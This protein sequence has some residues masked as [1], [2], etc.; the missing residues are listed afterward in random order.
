[1]TALV[2]KLRDRLGDSTLWLD[3]PAD[4]AAYARDWTGKHVG[5]TPLVLRPR[6]TEEVST[7]L[8]ACAALGVP[9][10]PQGG[11][12]GM[13]GGSVPRA[14]EVVLS[15]ERLDAIEDFDEG[16]ATVRV[17]AGVVLER[18]QG[19]LRE[20]GYDMPVDLGARGSCRIGGMIAT[21]AGGI[22]VLRY[23][24]MR[25][26]V[27]GLEV[28][29]ADGTVLDALN[30][31]KKN[32]TGLDLK[33]L[34]VGSEGI[35]GVVTRAVL[36]IQPAPE[37]FQ[38][39]LLAVPRRDLL[40]GLLADARARF[41][42]L[43]SLE[44]VDGATVDWLRSAD[45][46]FRSPLAWGHGSYVVIEEE[47]TAGPDAAAAFA[48]RLEGLFSDGLI[49]DAAVAN[50]GA[51]A[52]AIWRL[53]EAPTETVSRVG[54]THK[55]DVT[56]PPG[57]IPAFLDEMEAVASAEGGVRAI[58]FGHLGDGNVHVNMAQ[59]PGVP[60]DAFRAKEAVLAE[61]IY[62]AVRERRGSVSAEHGIG[63]MK[64]AYL[65]YS[66]TGGEIALMRTLKKT[67]D[68]KGILNP[69]VMLEP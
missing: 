56:V 15:T 37:A 33:Q 48:T 52:E 30:T 4:T 16:A 11:N 26:Q 59:E 10:V 54:L 53:R 69:G 5:E 66:R 60:D 51:Q 28:V 7:V 44:F 64:R 57:T 40:P 29:L 21:N 43:S 45:S 22:K 61:R 58:L 27:R 62:G 41:R 50:S 31:L 14:G 6:S 24:H 17:Q 49:A 19:H 8:A 46:A 2:E 63:V 20:R 42:G 25:E 65:P 32:N 3:D 1:M 67:L 39:A 47:S 18:L 38:T 9:L 12:T 13:V 68:P 34:F 23:G 36:Q 35:L 55:F